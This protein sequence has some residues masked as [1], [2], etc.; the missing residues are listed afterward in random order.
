MKLAVLS[1]TH[2]LLRQEVCA[3]IRDVD[4]ILHAGDFSSPRILAQ[5]EAIAPVYA[6]AGNNDR[7][8]PQPLPSSLSFALDG[9]RIYMTHRKK[10]LPPALG[11]YDL[12]IVGH[13]HR[14]GESR[15]DGA[16]VLN[17]GSCGPRRFRQSITFALVETAPLHVTRVELAH[18]A[19]RKTPPDI[20]T[21]VELVMRETEKGRSPGQIAA[22]F[23]LD[24]ALTEQIVRL[25]VTHPGVSAEGILTK[26]G[27]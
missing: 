14:Y 23:G 15:Q 22:R 19:Q 21:Q 24:T 5:L 11:D 17:P 25:I 27:L 10:D 9:V 3:Q 7:N 1:D 8:W 13:S 18:A 12:V 16:L 26:L 2:D 20:R 4:A 6:V